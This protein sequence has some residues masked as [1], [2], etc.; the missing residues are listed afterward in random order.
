MMHWSASS[1]NSFFFALYATRP[2][3]GSSY[4]TVY[5]ASIKTKLEGALANLIPDSVK[6]AMHEKMAKPKGPSETRPTD[7][8]DAA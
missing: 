1:E 2:R 6:S 4:S 8:K 7:K 3:G 5:A